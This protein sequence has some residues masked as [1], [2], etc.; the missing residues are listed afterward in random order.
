MLL[1]LYEVS[2]AILNRL[3]EEVV[4]KSFDYV[5]EKTLYPYIIVGDIETD[6]DSTKTGDGVKATQ[7]IQVWSRFPG[8]QEAMEIGNNVMVA[9]EKELTIANGEIWEQRFLKTKTQEIEEGIY[10]TEL[11]LKLNIEWGE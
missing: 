3:Q 9:L 1:K 11:K 6:D 5:P 4:T 7:T 2:K 10:A 8:K